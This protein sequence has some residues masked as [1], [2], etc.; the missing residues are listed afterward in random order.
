M[1]TTS[2]AD[3]KRVI[4]EFDPQNILEHLPRKNAE[5]VVRALCSYRQSAESS[6]D[7]TLDATE[8]EE[9]ILLAEHFPR[10]GSDRQLTKRA[11]M[12]LLLCAVVTVTLIV[13]GFVVGFSDYWVQQT[14]LDVLI[15]ALLWFSAFLFAIFCFV[16]GERGVLSGESCVLTNLRA[17]RVFDPTRWTRAYTESFWYDTIDPYWLQVLKEKK[18]LASYSVLF[19]PPP[20][21]L[22]SFEDLIASNDTAEAGGSPSRGGMRL[23]SGKR[24]PSE[25]NNVSWV[26]L[27]D[28]GGSSAESVVEEQAASKEQAWLATPADRVGFLRLGATRDTVL[29]MFR[30]IHEHASPTYVTFTTHHCTIGMLT[31]S[32]QERQ[33]PVATMEDDEWRDIEASL[34]SCRVHPAIIA[35]PFAVIQSLLLVFAVFAVA[36]PFFMSFLVCN[37]CTIVL[38][39]FGLNYFAFRNWLQVCQYQV[40]ERVDTAAKVLNIKYRMHSVL[41]LNRHMKVDVKSFDLCAAP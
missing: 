5:A 9:K 24:R 39:L 15:Q 10:Y 13:V 30:I 8:M 4:E 37:S 23:K 20:A 40:M 7:S 2:E 18:R 35:L 22:L 3:L 6:L 26:P 41:V 19:H 11:L 21:S 28:G 1:N 33:N 36:I 31:L 25:K 29:R 27:D 32:P 14:A 38:L 34:T 12:C 17:I 16:D